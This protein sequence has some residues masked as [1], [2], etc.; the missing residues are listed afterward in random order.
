MRPI[1]PNIPVRNPLLD[2]QVQVDDSGFQPLSIEWLRWFQTQVD[3]FNVV[4]SVN[5]INRVA[6]AGPYQAQPWDSVKMATPVPGFVDLPPVSENP[7]IE[8]SVFKTSGDA[9]ALTVKAAGFDRING[10][11]T[12]ATSIQYGKATFHNDGVS[13][14]YIK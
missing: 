12:W 8:I 2:P 3:Q 1:V 11:P 13:N 6:T 14:W 5:N 4:G 10:S 9:N 7:D